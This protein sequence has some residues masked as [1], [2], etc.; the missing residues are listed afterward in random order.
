MTLNPEPGGEGCFTGGRGIVIDYRIRADDG[1]LTAGYTRSRFPAWA[2]DGGHEGSP[3][4]IEFIPRQGERKRFAFVSGLALRK[5]DVVR[6]VSGN[7]GGLGDPKRRDPEA[8]R[9][10]VANGLLTTER[11]GEVYGIEV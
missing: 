11:A 8:V 9:R 2:L 5:D 10:D 1:F 7:G 3:N 4:Y 6:I